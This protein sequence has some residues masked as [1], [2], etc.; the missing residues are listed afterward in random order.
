MTTSGTVRKQVVLL[1]PSP[2]IINLSA[3]PPVI[4]SEAKDQVVAADDHLILRSAQ[5]E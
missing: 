3:T 1:S 4:L 5:K 2:V